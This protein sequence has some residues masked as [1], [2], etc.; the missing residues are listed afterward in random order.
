MKVIASILFSLFLCLPVAAEDIATVETTGMFVK[1]KLTV[2]AFNDPDF[3]S[4]AC[5]VTAPS[6]SLSFEDPSDSS[7]ACRLLG[8]APDTPTNKARVFGADKNLFF[9]TFRVDRF[10]DRRRN[11]LIYLAYTE[12]MSGDNQSHSVS[13]VPLGAALA[14]AHKPGLPAE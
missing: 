6:R 8:K 2:S 7:I 11:V 4:V 1:D 10:Y 13:V 9:K 12:K 5:Y 14:P 3:P